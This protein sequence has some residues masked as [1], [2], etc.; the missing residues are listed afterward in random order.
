MDRRGFLKSLA[1]GAA[2]ALLPLD[3]TVQPIEQEQAFDW[4]QWSK[5]SDGRLV[6]TM[7][8]YE[9]IA[10]Q[11]WYD[12]TIVMASHCII[13]NCRFE[14]CFISAQPDAYDC[15]VINNFSD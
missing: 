4:H 5:G 14:G 1:V 6:Y 9:V 7:E 3:L 8:P 11:D 13:R 15:F 12:A 2:T 10:E